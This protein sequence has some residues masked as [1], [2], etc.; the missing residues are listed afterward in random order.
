MT[1][2][3][4]TQYGNNTRTVSGTPGIYKDDVVLLCDTST[5]PVNIDLLQIPSGRWSTTWKLY[6]IDL[7]GNAATNN[8][9]INAGLGQT[10]NGSS[11]YVINTAGGCALVQITGNTQYVVSSTQTGNAAI[12][13]SGTNWSFV[14]ANT[15]HVGNASQLQAAY[16]AAKLATPDGAPLSATNRFTLLVA[17]GYYTF[18]SNFVMDTQFIDVVSITGNPDVIFDGAGTISITA[19]DVFVKGIDVTTKNFTLS[20]NLSSLVCENCIGGDN[21]FAGL[22]SASGLFKNCTGGVNAFGG[23]VTGIASGTFDKCTGGASSFGG[24]GG[25]A[26]GVFTNCTGGQYGFAGG[27]GIANGTFDGC[28][29]FNYSF[30]GGGAGVASGNFY[31]CRGLA[32]SFGGGSSGASSGVF[33]NCTG[34]RASFGGDGIASGTYTNCTGGDDSFGGG[35]SGGNVASGAFYNCVGAINAFGGGDNNGGNASGVFHNCTG[36]SGCFGGGDTGIGS[37][38][39]YSC[40]AGSESF[41]NTQCTGYFSYCVGGSASFGNNSN[42][43]GV[44]TG[45]LYWCRLTSGTFQTVSSGGRTIYCI[46]GNDNTNNQ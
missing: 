45:K 39:F 36:L 6:V 34:T 32:E 7:S 46:D 37:G 43:T 8:I 19:S 15:S 14:Y 29:S 31:N 35:D 12:A 13:F 10:I 40:F 20:T 33:S 17:P 21:S 38:D 41:G 25:T 9:T 18:A 30:G 5:G 28:I 27:G 4:A 1:Q 2:L 24:F 26:D 42:L 23:G 16:T 3:A 44:L 11:S 22:L